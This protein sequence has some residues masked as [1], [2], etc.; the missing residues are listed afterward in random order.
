MELRPY[1][2]CD[3]AEMADLFYNTVHTVNARDYTPEQ[4]NAWATGRVDLEGW[5]RSF[6]DHVTLVAW[7]DGKIIGF[8]DL[9]R[10]DYLDRLYVHKD[11]QGR[12]TATEICRQLESQAEGK[13]TTHASITA[14]PFFESRGYRVLRQQTVER[15]GVAMTNYVMVKDKM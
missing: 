6:L 5:N 2:P 15:F 1:R 7:E 11:W 13:I 9:E 8:G 12:G 3:C 14:R 10:P 4:L